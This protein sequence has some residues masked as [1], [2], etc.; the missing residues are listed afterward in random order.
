MD[1][2]NGAICMSEENQAEIVMDARVRQLA[3]LVVQDVER[4]I[5]EALKKLGD[6]NFIRARIE[7]VPYQV[8][9][10]P[11]PEGTAAGLDG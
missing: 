6:F 2:E 4:R 10:K 7:S 5:G 11:Q 1:T 9:R 3:G 8:R